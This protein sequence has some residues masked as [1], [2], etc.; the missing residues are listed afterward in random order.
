MKF[1]R[2]PAAWGAAV[3]AI[4]SALA[5]FDFPVLTGEHEPLLIAVVN[6][7]V[8]LAVALSVR[9]FAPSAITYLITAL[10]ALAAGYGLQVPENWVSGANTL[11]VALVFAM[12]RV[13]QTPKA[14][15]MPRDHTV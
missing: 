2:E 11:V 5:A 13:Q 9:P 8:G 10:A 3:V 1:S 6:A 14:A 4:I 7:V 15:P 12:T